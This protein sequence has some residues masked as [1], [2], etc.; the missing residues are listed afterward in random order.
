MKTLQGFAPEARWIRPESLH[1]TLKFIGEQPAERVDAIADRLRHIEAPSLQLKVAGHGFFPTAE[2]P[3]VFWIGVVENQGLT[4]L[5]MKCD[6]A[7]AELGIPQERRPYS[8]HLTL[9]RAS[10]RSS[11]SPNWRKGDR[12]NSIFSALQLPRDHLNAPDFGK[13]DVREFDLYR[14]QLS[15]TGSLYTKLRNFPLQSP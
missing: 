3:R 12:A 14:S 1:V 15:P 8:P 10:G 9:A 5:A 4:E 2:A 6:A 7:L 11:G 13:V